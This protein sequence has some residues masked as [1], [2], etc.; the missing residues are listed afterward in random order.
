MTIRPTFLISTAF[1]VWSLVSNAAVPAEP[2]QPPEEARQP[3]EA[4]Y[5][6]SEIRTF[7]VAAIQVQRINDAYLPRL[8]EAKTPED[9]EEVRNAAMTEMVNAVQ[10]NGMSVAKYN[11]ISKVVQTNPEVAAKVREHVMKEQ[12]N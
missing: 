11:E 10:N 6:D 7:V 12:A 2:A 4:S 8:K 1:A 3:A 5:S 9:Q